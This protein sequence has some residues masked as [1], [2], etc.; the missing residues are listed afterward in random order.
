MLRRLRH[1]E[2]GIA[3]PV[4]L[5]VLLIC[6]IVTAT[7]ANG[8]NR[9]TR[10]SGEDQW[11]KSAYAAANA[12]IDVAIAR[13]RT[14]GTQ[15]APTQCLTT[16]GVAPGT[17]GECPSYTETLGTGTSFTFTVTP[18]TTA[19]NG[20]FTLPG[21]VVPA[22]SLRRCITSTGTVNGVTRRVQAQVTAAPGTGHWVGILGLD[23]VMLD[24]S[25]KL[26]AC[27][28]PAT[29]L[30]ASNAWIDATANS[31]VVLN[32]NCP[33]LSWTLSTPAGGR[34]Q[35]H[36]DTKPN[37][38]LTK[39]AQAPYAIDPPPVDWETVEQGNDNGRLASTSSDVSYV[40]DAR[41]NTTTLVGSLGNDGKVVLKRGG[42]YYLCG[43][44]MGNQGSLDF[45]TTEKTRIF[46]DSPTRS[47]S[48]CQTGTGYFRTENSA[49]FNW[50]SSVPDD[51]TTVLSNRAK[52][53]ELYFHGNGQDL[54]FGNQ[55]RF[56]GLL[57]A[58]RT[59]VV[60]DNS[61][62]IF[63]AVA[64]KEVRLTNGTWFR[65]PIGLAD[66]AGASNAWRPVGVGQCRSTAPVPTDP[67]SGC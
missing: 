33:N 14:L 61:S 40:G 28:Q 2:R 37:E 55:I 54:I 27:P 57:H 4:T 13:L 35:W 50:P 49:R 11:S 22:G 59:K 53:V 46:I 25:P 26:D 31:G 23:G 34:I 38:P 32:H 56:A 63:G 64:A 44:S 60:Y 6:L 17:N 45:S 66:L 19:A 15:V 62:V 10:T 43:L 16:A 41:F 39:Q 36:K 7:V 52:N 20:C 12:G 1:D 29:P 21:T 48:P 8:A 51:A 5:G 24:N 47:G 65:S 58:P 3:M 30:V 18:A 42:T 9:L 67:E